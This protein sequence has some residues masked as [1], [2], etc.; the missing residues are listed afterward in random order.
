MKRT[1]LFLTVTIA[2]V[3]GVKAQQQTATLQRG[4]STTYY[5]GEDAFKEAYNAA[6]DEAIITLSAGYFNTVDSIT[7]QITIRGNGYTGNK[8][9]IGKTINDGVPLSLIIHANNVRLEGLSTESTIYVSD[10]KNLYINRSYVESFCAVNGEIHS[11]VPYHANTIIDQCWVDFIWSKN[12]DNFCIKNSFI[13]DYGTSSITV[14]NNNQFFNCVVGKFEPKVSYRNCI[15]NVQTNEGTVSFRD[16]KEYYNNVF[17]CGLKVKSQNYHDVSGYY[18]SVISIDESTRYSTPTLPDIETSN[19]K[20]NSVA[21]FDD[22]FN[23]TNEENPL[24]APIIT[25]ITG[26]DGTMVGPYGGTGFSEN[27]SI[28]RI[29]ESKIDTYTDGE[30]KLN[31]KVKVEVGQ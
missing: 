30:G 11:I 2:M 26:D 3:M 19:I 15:I 14:N 6:N 20:G 12:D 17:I 22:I 21:L 29:T 5:F 8:T 28:P 23:Y 18:A 25:I 10:T 1:F 31:V 7:K 24:Y 9:V 16:D 4:N 27:P 13:I